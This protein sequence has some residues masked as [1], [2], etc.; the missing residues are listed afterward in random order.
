MSLMNLGLSEN[1]CVA[2][3]GELRTRYLASWSPSFLI[4][5]VK[6][7]WLVPH[8]VL[9]RIHTSLKVNTQKWQFFLP[10]GWSLSG[11]EAQD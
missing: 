5:K 10:K 2:N 7:N 1:L 11:R 3:I 8:K 6:T 4:Y 9:Q